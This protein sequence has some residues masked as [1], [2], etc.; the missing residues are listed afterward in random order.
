MAKIYKIEITEDERKVL[1]YACGILSVRTNEGIK[2]HT[3][4]NGKAKKG[5]GLYVEGAKKRHELATKLETFFNEL[6][7]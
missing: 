5:Y 2:S 6:K 3:G 4:K 7:K 1:H